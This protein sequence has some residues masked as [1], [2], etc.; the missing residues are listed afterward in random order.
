MRGLFP[1]TISSRRKAL[2]CSG[3][4]PTLG[5]SKL[6][7]AVA[8]S[9][10]VLMRSHP[11]AAAS[12]RSP[13]LGLVLLTLSAVG[14]LSIGLPVTPA[15]AAS[16][17][18]VVPTTVHAAATAAPA[19]L[20][21][22]GVVPTAPS[23]SHP[24]SDPLW[25]PLR[26]PARISCAR[27][28]CTSGTYHGYWAIDF[29]GDRGD[30]IYAAGAGVLHVGAVAP[31]C[32]T[33]AKDIEAGTWVWVDHG[34]G[35][36]TKYNHLDAII[37]KEG[38]RVTAQTL[39]GRMGHSGDILPCTTNYLHFE[40]RT[41]GVTG[42]RVNPGTMLMCSAGTRIRMPDAR[43]VTSWDDA[44]L[45]ERDA[46]TPK[47]TS[48]CVTSTWNATPAAPGTSVRSGPR[49]ATVSW[50][51][52][53]AGTNRVVVLQEL[54]SPSLHRYGWPTYVVLPAASR[55]RTFTGLTNGRT[56]RYRAAFHN[57]YGNSAWSAARSVIPASV[58]ATPK[59][60]RFLTSPTRDYIHYGW[61][62][63]TD[64]GS[65]VT[66]YRAARRCLVKGAYGPWAYTDVRPT[67]YYTNFR[68]LTGIT[69]CQVKVRASNRVGNSAWS[70]VSGIR[71][72]P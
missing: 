42:A 2:T 61:W 9:F 46:E 7:G 28:N 57:G 21:G 49:S 1:S 14:S 31:G 69:T 54:W 20:A 12:V 38:Q 34:G 16:A 72:R 51:A 40:V 5:K 44:R 36:V 55:S 33:R 37:A 4:R 13:L 63:S 47:G 66:S 6:N 68:G 10:E 35:T 18:V 56:Y 52:P 43:G 60:P 62:K 48:A 39:I 30:G 23:A 71:K 50:K 58:P 29:V 26:D 19:V 27:S 15:V 67:V 70:Q 59:A 64:N 3:P 41:G 8:Y 24:F 53:P 22:A 65:A 45:P 25:L 32:K 11:F 17:S